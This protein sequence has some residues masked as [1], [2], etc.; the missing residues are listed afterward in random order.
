MSRGHDLLPTMGSQICDCR[1]SRDLIFDFHFGKTLR[2][3]VQ[4]VVV[5]LDVACPSIRAVSSVY[6]GYETI[7]DFGTRSGTECW[8]KYVEK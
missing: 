5:A 4:A 6:L 8:M 2:D 1:R 3:L 7:P